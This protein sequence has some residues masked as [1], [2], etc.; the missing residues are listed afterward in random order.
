MHEA[1]SVAMAST[2]SLGCMPL[3]DPD[4]VAIWEGFERKSDLALPDCEALDNPALICSRD[5][6]RALFLTEREHLIQH[7]MKI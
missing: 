5:L 4:L 2:V 7:Q 1:Y 3:T 6:L